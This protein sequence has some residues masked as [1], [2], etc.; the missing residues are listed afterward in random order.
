MSRVGSVN[1]K[2]YSTTPQTADDVWK[3]TVSKEQFTQYTSAGAG[4]KTPQDTV[5]FYALAE[6]S[7]WAKPLTGTVKAQPKAAGLPS[8]YLNTL[9]QHNGLNR[10]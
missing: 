10:N 3:E 5:S 9:I 6:G 4:P 2:H 1:F 8:V 7:R